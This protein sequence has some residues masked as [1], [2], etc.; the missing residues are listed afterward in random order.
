VKNI[1]GVI[2]VGEIFHQHL[3]LVEIEGPNQQ[4]VEE[5]LGAQVFQ[6]I[7]GRPVDLVAANDEAVAGRDV[8]LEIGSV[9]HHVE[10]F[11]SDH[12]VKADQAD[13][14]GAAK[15]NIAADVLVFGD[16]AFFGAAQRGRHVDGG[17]EILDSVELLRDGLD[18]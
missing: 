2:L 8:Q 16:L 5:V 3:I 12:G 17:A 10:G 4:R 13:V 15:A 11:V 6:L 14:G 9:G 1:G 7:G 18:K